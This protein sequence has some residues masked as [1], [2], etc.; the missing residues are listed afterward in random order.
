MTTASP[1]FSTGNRAIPD[2]GQSKTTVVYGGITY[3]VSPSGFINYI[4]NV[5]GNSYISPFFPGPRS[6]F[7]NS[8]KYS[9]L[10]LSRVSKED[11]QILKSLPLYRRGLQNF[12]TYAYTNAWAADGVTAFGKSFNGYTGV[13]DTQ[14]VNNKILD[15]WPITGVCQSYK[16]LKDWLDGASANGAIIDA[17]LIDN[18]SSPYEPSWVDSTTYNAL[19]GDTRY[20]QT[21]FGLTSWYDIYSSQGGCADQANTISNIYS[22]WA[23]KEAY[24]AKA[25]QLSYL[26]AMLEHNPNSLTSNYTYFKEGEPLLKEGE[27]NAV[28][29]QDGSPLIHMELGGNA[30][31]PE[32]YGGMRSTNGS[33]FIK[34][35]DGKHLDIGGFINYFRCFNRVMTRGPWASFVLTLAEARSAKRGMP[36]APLTPWIGSVDWTG[37]NY[38]LGAKEYEIYMVYPWFG[39]YQSPPN[40]LH[41]TTWQY[42]LSSVS[43]GFTGEYNGFTGWNGSTAAFRVVTPK[44]G[45]TGG[46]RG[47]IWYKSN[48]IGV[49]YDGS[50]SAFKFTTVGTTGTTASVALYYGYPSL[51]AGQTYVFSYEIDLDRGYTGSLARFITWSTS[52]DSLTI[53]NQPTSTTQS[54]GFTFQQVLP[55][56]GSWANGFTAIQYNVGD[57]GWTKVSWKFVADSS[58]NTS[59]TGIGMHVYYGPN[60]PTV[61]GGYEIY[62]RNPAFEIEG[63][64]AISINKIDNVYTKYPAYAVYQSPRTYSSLQ[65]HYHGITAGITYIFSYYRNLNSGSTVAPPNQQLI[66]HFRTWSYNY[67]RGISFSRVLPSTGPQYFGTGPADLSGYSGWTEISYEFTPSKPFADIPNNDTL[68][69]SLIDILNGY[70][71]MNDGYNLGGLTA[72]YAHPRLQIKGVSA[73]T[74]LYFREATDEYNY[75]VN[76]DAPPSGFANMKLGYNPRQGAYIYN[77]AGHSGYYYDYVRHLALLGTKYFGYFNPS[78]FV[79]M[80]FTGA[81]TNW[82]NRG[83]GS[84][85]WFVNTQSFQNG[86]TGW[87]SEQNEFNECLKDINNRLGGFTL[88]TADYSEYDWNSTYMAHGAPTTA[89]NSWW[90][91]VTVKPG[92]TMICN[93]VTLSSAD[94]YPVGTWVGTS[95]PTL[96]GIG[97]TWKAWDLPQ[98]PGYT[99]PNKVFDFLGMTSNNQITQAGFSCVRSTT[100]TYIDSTG[101]VKTAAINEPRLNYDQDT[102]Q[103]KG[104]IVEAE[105]TN[106]LNFSET[107]A[108]SGGCNNNWID[109][110]LARTTGFTS[111]SGLTNAI[112]FTATAANAILVATNGVTTGTVYGSWSCWFRG[113]TGNE[114]VYASIDGGTSWKQI[115]KLSNKW[116]RTGSELTMTEVGMTQS[117]FHMAFRLGNTNDSVEI[118]GAQVEERVRTWS[119]PVPIDPLLYVDYTSYVPS[120][121]TRG[122]R[123]FEN[124]RI[125]GSSFTSWFGNTQGS[126]FFDVENMYDLAIV[127]TSQYYTQGMVA[128]SS[129]GGGGVNITR[130]GTDLSAGANNITYWPYPQTGYPINVPFKFMYTY[131]PYTM[132]MSVNGNWGTS[133]YTGITA[134]S[135]TYN[136]MIFSVIWGQHDTRIQSQTHIRKVMYWDYIWNSDDMNAMTKANVDQ[137][138]TWNQYG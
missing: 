122:Y 49:T 91:R 44:L 138:T 21:Y 6:N 12:N 35:F 61:T 19:R 17:L 1:Y 26:Q 85:D 29:P 94:G 64:T 86:W 110:N 136:A 4:N 108:T 115:T 120:G 79:D 45:V 47:G 127:N 42:N 106:L 39:T 3:D 38:T 93:G 10:T 13:W 57:S 37:P 9:G 116:R 97:L 82:A 89:G 15:P 134:Y 2:L 126:I 18:E 40:V 20:K 83:F 73:N 125:S 46:P 76:A 48:V 128:R 112:R 78:Q 60:S 87:L 111:P 130:W 28:W 72:Y 117:P 113:V 34:P 56:A 121:I 32:L 71:I 107:F 77:R 66:E 23:A 84:N 88:T 131:S 105:T 55:V 103:P 53:P 14:F 65:Y 7:I 25:F 22:W 133:T 31:S 118:W 68:K 59:T 90:W 124:C 27:R 41:T 135:Q 109:I 30:A 96:A 16:M 137:F 81:L 33:R 54:T 8:S 119:T 104:F 74:D 62:V 101:T 36:S 132:K 99:A 50:T 95:G 63:S 98:E 24:Q 43:K 100:A 11:Y 51:T 123:G 102:L 5:N 75:A 67:P 129:G 52:N 114:T 69:I 58:I 92:Y 70:S 80:G